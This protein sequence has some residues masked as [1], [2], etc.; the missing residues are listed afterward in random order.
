MAASILQTVEDEG[1]DGVVL[2]SRGLGVLEGFLRNSVSRLVLE[3]AN[4][5]VTIVK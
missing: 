3:N 4:V 5:P 1:C 2:G